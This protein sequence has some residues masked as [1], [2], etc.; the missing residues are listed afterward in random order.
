MNVVDLFFTDKLI[1]LIDKTSR[2]SFIFSLLNIRNL[3][4]VRR[5]FRLPVYPC[6]TTWLL[7][8]PHLFFSLFIL[9]PL[10]LPRSLLL[11][12]KLDLACRVN[13]TSRSAFRNCCSYCRDVEYRP[14]SMR[15]MQITLK[16]KERKRE[17]KW[18]RRWKRRVGKVYVW[19]TGENARTG[20]TNSL[21]FAFPCH[22]ER[23][24]KLFRT[25]GKS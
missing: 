2:T 10:P 17:R 20:Y 3:S 7:H 1:R 14:W 15:A 18:E 9:F 22:V 6:L 12:R 24:A 25:G 21:E 4:N 16:N 5:L 8:H 19:K 11:A 13:V 23:F